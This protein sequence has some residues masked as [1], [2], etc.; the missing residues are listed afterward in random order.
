MAEKQD[1]KGKIKE[2]VSENN[3]PNPNTDFTAKT[4][5]TANTPE[6]IVVNEQNAV[7]IDISQEKLNSELNIENNEK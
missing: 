2:I 5:I 1:K 6:V 7:N 4:A 3:N